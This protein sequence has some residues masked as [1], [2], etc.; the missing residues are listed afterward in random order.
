MLMTI[1][2]L[3]HLVC[4]LTITAA[5][6]AQINTPT[7]ALFSSTSEVI[8]SR[9]SAAFV[10]PRT[11]IKLEENIKNELA[12]VDSM[13]LSVV[14]GKSDATSEEMINYINEIEQLIAKA[15]V[16]YQNAMEIENELSSYHSLAIYEAEKDESAIILLEMIETSLIVAR[17]V[18]ND[19]ESRIMNMESTLTI[20]RIELETQIKAEEEARLKKELEKQEGEKEGDF[21]NENEELVNEVQ[22]NEEVKPITD[23]ESQ[24]DEEKA[25]DRFDDE[26]LEKPEVINDA[27]HVDLRDN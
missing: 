22:E 15:N 4:F 16:S 10:F 2:R 25:E 7:Y 13:G 27:V 23:E 18:L 20:V 6:F 12:N 14:G 5:I 24:I 8:E 26:T 21:Q 19:I 9:I 17:D 1:K 11:I 3:V